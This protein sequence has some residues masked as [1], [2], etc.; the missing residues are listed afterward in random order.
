M[1]SFLIQNPEKTIQKQVNN[2]CESYSNPH[3]VIAELTQNSVDA[4]K[5]WNERHP[6][7][8]KEHFINITIDSTNNYIKVEDSGVGIDVEK[9]PDLLAPNATDKDGNVLTIGEKG[10]GLTYCIFCSN[11]FN[12]RTKSES[13]VFEG[14]INNARVWRNEKSPENIPDI[15][16]E[17]EEDQSD[18]EQT[19]TIIELYDVV[20]SDE[21]EKSIFDLSKSRLIY[22]LRTKTALG[23]TKKRH[24]DNEPD[25]DITLDIQKESGNNKEKITD[26]YKFPDTFWD[27]SDV[28]DLEEFEDRDDIARMSDE[29]KRENL[30]DKIWKVEGE[31]TR[32]SGTVRYYAVFV[33]STKDWKRIAK[34]NK[35]HDEENSSPDIQHGIYIS[36]RGMPTGIELSKPKVGSK[37]YWGN[38]FILLG[39]DG[40]Q[41]D[42]GRKSVPSRTKGMLKDIAKDIYN[43]FKNWRQQIIVNTKTPSSKP[44]QLVR[45]ERSEKFDQM[46]RIRNLDA[47]E[48]E[49][50]KVPDDQEAGVVAIFH[51][52]IGSGVLDNYRCYRAGY[53][54]DYDFWGEYI[55]TA[56]EIGDDY[57]EDVD[58]VLE[59]EVVIE[60]KYE[61]ADIIQDVDEERK[62]LKD[63]DLLVAWDIDKSRFNE[64]TIIA[65]KL[66]ENEKYFVGSNYKLK[67]GTTNTTLDHELY[68]IS[69]SSLLE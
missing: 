67:P 57:A 61:A 16:P 34:Q 46:N 52:L 59:Q 2:I 45:K 43:N 6:D 68:V 47:D 53:N 9:L 40:F 39:Y 15:E 27:E 31:I 55:A 25:I 65:T 30:E 12:I 56:E 19:G 22:L 1:G 64:S 14:E 66:D 26:E 58:N 29:E 3:D 20:C 11:K 69:L 21:D 48:I 4:I 60:F 54:Q 24:G 44:T 23:N 33:Q 50:Q 36:T 32:S 62:Y 35:I 17:L 49:Y 7:V 5:E 51:E 28:I 38:T 18:P 37:G 41:F 13:G 10:V 42:L 8:S 63:I